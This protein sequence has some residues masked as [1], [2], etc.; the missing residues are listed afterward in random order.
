MRL[1]KLP[2]FLFDKDVSA[3][4][5]AIVALM[6]AYIISPIDLI[7]EAIAG[8]GIIDDAVLTMYVL[9]TISSKLDFY[10][11]QEI[12]EAD[13]DVKKPITNAEYKFIDENEEETE[14][15]E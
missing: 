7:P 9:S 5:K 6:F 1:G 8:L 15:K 3:I 4:Q 14:E 13:G 12:E 10:I 2:K 11:D